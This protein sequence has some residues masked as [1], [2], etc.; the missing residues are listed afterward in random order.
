MPYTE[1]E[2]FLKGLYEERLKQKLS[3]KRANGKILF[4]GERNNIFA[5]Y[6]EYFPVK[7]ERIMEVLRNNP[8][9]RPLSVVA[10]GFEEGTKAVADAFGATLIGPAE[11]FRTMKEQNLFPPL[12]EESAK[13]RLR[14]TK[15]LRDFLTRK[16][17]KRFFALGAWM[18]IFSLFSPFPTYYLI[19]GG[20]FLCLSA[21]CLLFGVKT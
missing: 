13:T 17:S 21:F 9:A 11:L 20:L 19:S 6:P 10:C 7:A 2:S 3:P 12:P 1:A 4:Y 18:T 15:W 5:F 8:T 14:L 16:R